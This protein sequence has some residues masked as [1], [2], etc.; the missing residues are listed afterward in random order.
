PAPSEQRVR[1]VS[2]GRLIEFK[3]FQHLIAA[4][5]LAAKQSVRVEVE[6]L[7][8]GPWRERLE[9]QAKD[10]KVADRVHFRGTVGL[11]EMKTSFGE[12]DVFALPCIFS[13]EGAS[14]M[15]PTV[16]TEAMFT[17]L[18]VVSTSV[19]GV[20]EL[21]QDGETGFVL[22]PGD[23]DGLAEVLIRLARE[24]G[25]AAKLGA[26]G[27]QR[28][29]QMF[30]RDVTLP[31][32]MG[33]FEEAQEKAA[34]QKPQ[35]PELV[36][37]YDLAESDAEHVA[38][39]IPVVHE[40]R[41]QCWLAGGHAKSS[42][43]KQLPDLEK[44]EWLPDGL[45]LEMEWR[46]TESQRTE[47]TALRAELGTSVD[48]E[49]FFNT[50]RRAVWLAEAIRRRGGTSLI[51]APGGET[52]LLAW[53]ISQRLAIPFVSAFEKK[54][55]FPKKLRTRVMDDARAVACAYD[56]DPLQR[57]AKRLKPAAR[58]QALRS[59]LKVHLVS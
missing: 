46:A 15:F 32:L 13:E 17:G 40:L 11:D 22:E 19:A 2:C 55:E 41:G 30:A 35:P 53:M 44:L 3:G 52:C 45:V 7:G 48:G 25:L 1:V 12:S 39:E 16:I 38:L 54:S 23:E 58:Q 31:Q 51:Y 10:L 49:T 9:A 20:P 5:A 37:I 59:W 56:D 33:K 21:V 27:K 50:A 42:D 28:A 26:G 24:A 47:W 14:D 36:A 29:H 18:P 6:L 34:R 57:S 43:L 4:S 8:D